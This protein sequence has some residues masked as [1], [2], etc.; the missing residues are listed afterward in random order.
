M[1][2]L[3]LKTSESFIL[4]FIQLSQILIAKSIEIAKKEIR[5]NRTLNNV[6]IET[7]YTTG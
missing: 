5:L 6:R 2:Y 3:L 1:F 4:I 7:G